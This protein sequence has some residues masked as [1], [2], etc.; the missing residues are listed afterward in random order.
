[1]QPTI[2]MTYHLTKTLKLCGLKQ[3]AFI[4]AHESTSQLGGSFGLS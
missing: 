1:M 3:S 4:T 2:L